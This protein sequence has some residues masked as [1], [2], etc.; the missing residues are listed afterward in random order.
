MTHELEL[1]LSNPPRKQPLTD[2][3]KRMISVV[4]SINSCL[5]E[6]GRLITYIIYVIV[7]ENDRVAAFAYFYETLVSA[8]KEPAWEFKSNPMIGSLYDCAN[9]HENAMNIKV[10]IDFEQSMASGFKQM[11]T[12]T[13]RHL[14]MLDSVAEKSILLYL[15]IF[16][17]YEDCYLRQYNK[18][19]VFGT[20]DFFKTLF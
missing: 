17:G 1:F 15:K 3:I 4:C 20:K 18:K 5:T 13:V 19:N 8:E 2:E 14:D 9:A 11:G 10:E 6:V 16:G 7:A 12:D